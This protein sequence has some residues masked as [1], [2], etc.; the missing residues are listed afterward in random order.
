[1]VSA[2]E[3]RIVSVTVEP[4]AGLANR[5]RVVAAALELADRLRC[6]LRLVWTRTGALGCRF[7]ELFQPIAGVRVAEHAWN[8]SRIERLVGSRVGFY[9]YLTAPDIER[10]SR[11]D[12]FDD[13]AQARRPYLITFSRFLP[14]TGRLAA[15][16]PIAEVAHVVERTAASFTPHTIGVHIRRGDEDPSTRGPLTA[17]IE[18]FLTAMQARLDAEPQTNFF[19]ACDSRR[20]EARVL[21]TFGARV[22]T[23][24]K[25]LDRRT[26]DAIRAALVDLLCLSRTP[27]ILGSFYSSFSEMAAEMGGTRLEI[28]RDRE[29]W[30]A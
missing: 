5:M 29:G 8:T 1:M 2:S 21:S 3:R 16:R 24:P 6:P 10:R 28:V 9:T 13:L 25:S 20:D 26:R 14:S 11:G 22:T 19:L 27:L 7:D 15:L 18:C 12:G 23:L 30:A 4:T 17:P